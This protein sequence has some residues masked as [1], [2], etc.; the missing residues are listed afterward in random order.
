[1]EGDDKGRKQ[2][3]SEH[4]RLV[5]RSDVEAGVNHV[6]GQTPWETKYPEQ[7]FMASV[8]VGSRRVR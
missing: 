6:A 8:V 4:L 3:V 2:A 7:D 1:M 5:T